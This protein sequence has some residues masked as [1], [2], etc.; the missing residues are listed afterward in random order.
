MYT[1]GTT[2][3]PKDVPLTHGNVLCSARNIAAHYALTPEDRSLVV[4]PLFHGLGLIGAALSTLASGGVL[5]VPPRFSASSFWP[6]LRKHQ[7]TWYKR[8]PP[9]PPRCRPFSKCY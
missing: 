4:M 7:A 3:Q 2:S 9:L 8:T 6:L 1:S 5:I